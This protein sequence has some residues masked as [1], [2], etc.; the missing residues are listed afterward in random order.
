VRGWKLESILVWEQNVESIWDTVVH[1]AWD[2][3]RTWTPDFACGHRLFLYV[4]RGSCGKE[5]EKGNY[6]CFLVFFP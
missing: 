4:L 2:T 3:Y 5:R 1:H 6:F